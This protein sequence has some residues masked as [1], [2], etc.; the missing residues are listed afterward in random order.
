MDEEL[1]EFPCD[2]PVKAMGFA[3]SDFEEHIVGLVT[4]H[5][6]LATPRQVSIKESSGGRYLSVTVSVEARSREHLELIY[7]DL[8][9]DERVVFIL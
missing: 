9:A 6:S 2:F 4:R 8:K 7:A 3:T 1:L 5:A